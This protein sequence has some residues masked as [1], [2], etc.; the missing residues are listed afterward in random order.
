MRRLPLALAAVIIAAGTSAQAQAPMKTTYSYDRRGHETT[1]TQTPTE[2]SE[3]TVYYYGPSPAQKAKAQAEF[4][5]H[6]QCA[7][8]I[9]MPDP[10]ARQ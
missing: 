10:S 8:E 2:P 5:K 4:C 1:I 7:T 3:Q 9:P 6:F